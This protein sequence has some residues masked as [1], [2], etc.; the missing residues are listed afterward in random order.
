MNT[1]VFEVFLPG[2]DCAV[3]PYT[4]GMYSSHELAKEAIK[5]AR[6]EADGWHYDEAEIMEHPLDQPLKHW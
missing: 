4:V 1:S 5:K 6:R 3:Q 2:D